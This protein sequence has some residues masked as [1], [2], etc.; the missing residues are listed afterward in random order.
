MI[1]R[2]LFALIP[3]MVCAAGLPPRTPLH[4]AYRGTDPALWTRSVL[5][6]SDAATPSDFNVFPCGAPYCTVSRIVTDDAGNIYAVG[7]RTFAVSDRA[8][9]VFVAKLD[10]SGATIFVAT[11]SGKGIDTG[12]AIAVDPAGNIYV[13]GDTSSPNFPLRNAIQSA[14]NTK[15]FA[16]TGFLL[17]LSSD[18]SQLIY[19]T[20]FGG[21]VAALA[22]DDGGNVYATGE[23]GRTD[24]PV[25]PGMPNGTIDG[26]TI[27]QIIGAFVA[28]LNATGDKFVYSGRISG[29]SAGCTPGGTCFVSPRVTVGVAIALDAAGNA[30]VAGNANVTDLPT[31]PGVLSPSGIGAWV[32]RINAS[33]SRLDYL[34][35]LGTAKY[36]AA[37]DANAGNLASDLAVDAVGNAYLAGQTND[38]RFPAT[39]GAFQSKYNGPPALPFY[40]PPTDGF[41]AKLNPQATAVV[42]ATFLG[43]SSDDAAKAVAID[44]DGAAYVTGT[45]KSSDF[46]LTTGPELGADFVAVLSPTGSALT[47][48]A[49]FHE[50]TVS[51]AI[52]VD[53]DRRLRVGGV[54]G[55]ISSLSPNTPLATRVFGISDAAQGTPG[56]A[57]APGEVVSLFGTRLGPAS[58]VSGQAGSSGELPVTLAGTQVLFDGVAAPLLY[59]S[60]TQVNAVTP[61]ALVSGKSSN[62][63]AVVGTAASPVL[64]SIVVS[65]QPAIFT[66]GAGAAALNQDGTINSV[67]NPARRGSIV[68]IWA[69]GVGIVYP[70]PADGE[71]VSAAQNYE[72][73]FVLVNNHEYADV[74][75]GGAA[76]GMVAGVVQINFRL[77]ADLAK[78]VS[79]VAIGL[80]TNMSS[81][82]P[83]S[84]PTATVYV[85][86]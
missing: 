13:G 25:T 83:S 72:C 10:S 45:T 61:F 29:G 14:P 74:L 71:V 77:P 39:P 19:S 38:P 81:T 50:S 36:P 24:F 70:M 34:T 6:S 57:V 12:S 11:F 69:T 3:A 31:T 2:F 78:G 55:V 80:S 15:T 64:Q 54:A 51:A 22:A 52:A 9:D 35:Y 76:P 16:Y 40:I 32:A 17:K 43:G 53:A 26:T 28:K 82:S 58:G 75:Y 56:V 65:S 48:S 86:P 23:T 67:S 60:E 85:A 47:W 84:G 5:T 59:V 20:Y 44:S 42:Y 63:K 4:Y 49:R 1:I 66:N 37:S 68:S 79:E 41:V 27:P 18:G 8:S 62:V 30:Y 33:G 7:S 21:P 46:P 73:C